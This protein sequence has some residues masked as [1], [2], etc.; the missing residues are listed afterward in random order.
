MRY[1]K[2]LA[3]LFVAGLALALSVSAGAKHKPKV[4]VDCAPAAP[5][6]FHGTIAAVSSDSFSV[7]IEKVKPRAVKLA[8]KVVTFGVY[9]GTKIDRDGDRNLANVEPEDRAKVEAWACLDLEAGTVKL[10]A[11][12]LDAKP[13]SEDEDEHEDGD[14]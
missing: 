3:L 2:L 12:K 6:H 14:A 10:L 8:G 1:S 9:H 11:R 13:V 4:A 7:T 5:M